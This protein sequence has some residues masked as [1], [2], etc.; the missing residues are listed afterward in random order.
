MVDPKRVSVIQ[1]DVTGSVI[2]SDRYRGVTVRD[3]KKGIFGY[4]WFLCSR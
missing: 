2:L 3:K 4:K 1:C